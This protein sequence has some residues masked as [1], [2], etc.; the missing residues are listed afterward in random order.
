MDVGTDSLVLKSAPESDGCR[1]SGVNNIVKGIFGRCREFNFSLDL[2][3]L[4]SS[5]TPADF[6]S[7][8]VS[9]M[10]FM[11]SKRAW[12]QVER[13]FGPHI[14][15]LM[16]L[17]SNCQH[18]RTGQ[19]LPHFTP[20][21]TPCSSGF[22]V[23]AQSL[24]S[25]HNLFV[26]PPFVLIAPLLKYILEQDFHGAFTIIILDLRP[27]RLWRALLQSL[28]VDQVLLGRKSEVDVLLFPSQV[29]QHWSSRKL[30]RD[31]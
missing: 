11:L 24:P 16:S 27:R 25:D 15:D 19:C 12:G 10:D 1:S 4:P 31:L 2:R 30:Q 14:F 7:R 13:L 9:D 28:A 18:D 3:Y 29:G 6:L 8:K 23:F 20:C 17:D 22:N 26:F 21:T 5:T